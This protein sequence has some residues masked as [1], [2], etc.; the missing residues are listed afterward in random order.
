MKKIINDVKFNQV[1]Q[2]FK[3]LLNNKADIDHDHA[4]VYAPIDHTHT[5][6]TGSSGKSAY[7]IACDNG[8]DGDEVAWL[9]SL[10]GQNGEDYELTED[11]KTEIAEI[12]G[13][14]HNHDSDY[15][16]IGHDHDSDYASVG[17]THSTYL[18]IH[19]ADTAFAK[20]GHNHDGVYADADHVH[21][22]PTMTVVALSK[23]ATNTLVNDI[24]QHTHTGENSGF[25]TCIVMHDEENCIVFDTGNDIDPGE[26]LH[27]YLLSQGINTIDALYISHNHS[28]HFNEKA[29]HRLL[30]GNGIESAKISVNRLVVPHSAITSPH[31]ELNLYWDLFYTK[32][33][34]G[35][36]QILCR[37][38]SDSEWVYE[39]LATYNERHN[40]NMVITRPTTEGG[41]LDYGKFH[42]SCHNV[43]KAYLDAYS[44]WQY[45]EF[46]QA[47]GHP[48][49]NNYS[50]VNVVTYAG[51]K[52]VVAGDIMEPATEKMIDDGVFDYADLIFIPH[53]GLDINLPF[54]AF[55][56]LN[57]RH[58]VISSAYDGYWSKDS[59]SNDIIV[60]TG[61]L[62]T[63]SRPFAGELLK[64]GC[65]VT[66]TIG[67]TEAKNAGFF[68]TEQGIFV[69]KDN[70]GILAGAEI[71]PCGLKPD[72]NLDDL[73]AGRYYTYS[74]DVATS[75]TMNGKPP[76]PNK[77]IL[78]VDN[79]YTYPSS[80]NT[81]AFR[82]QTAY[83]IDTT[84]TMLI[85]RRTFTASAYSDWY[86]F[87]GVK[88]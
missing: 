17:H 10:K 63:V 68:V 69:D 1:I 79:I 56:R 66:S 86:K 50:M 21:Q 35:D 25:G 33:D 49:Y 29:L 62:E 41:N 30:T 52:I 48:N 55:N 80:G 47:K 31:S 84:D 88:A 43:S 37:N 85:T 20:K 34:Q 67:R 82:T 59:S 39:T 15:A 40:S 28:D 76:I 81:G 11:D 6:S 53:H 24:G 70:P 64:K 73:P 8:F 72:Q 51:K 60:W 83:N 45:N 2:K 65:R 57:A 87:T 14:N 36:Y 75:A 22:S 5:G 3:L 74:D 19:N 38:E 13:A 16:P 7:E 46:L 58:A 54:N 78:D 71:S 42:I 44:S 61:A 12:A 77:F 4:T 23:A 32:N 18:T 27:N 9:E 26:T